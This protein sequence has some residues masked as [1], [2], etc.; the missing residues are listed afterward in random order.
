MK[1]AIITVGSRGDVEPF[2]ALAARLLVSGHTVHF[3]VQSDLKD[4]VPAACQVHTLPFT[5]MDF[6]KFVGK[7]SHG[8]DHPNP[9]VGFVGTVTDIIAGLVLPCADQLASIDA[10]IIV[11]SALARQLAFAV[12]RQKGIPAALVHLQPL[13]PTG[14]FSHYSSW[15]ECV[16]LI[17]E[18]KQAPDGSGPAPSSSNLESYIELEK[19]QFDFL[20]DRLQ[21]TYDQLGIPAQSFED[22]RAALTGNNDAIL[23][24]NAFAE[25]LVPQ[26]KDVGPNVLSVGPLADVYL[27][28]GF[29]PPEELVEFLSRCETR[30]ICVGFGSMPF[31]KA[32]IVIDVIRK[33]DSPAVFVGDALMSKEDQDEWYKANI[34]TISSVQYAW[35]LPR[36]SMML[37]HGGAGVVMATMR[38]GIPAVISPLMGDQ[39]FW[40]RLLEALSL[41]ARAGALT[42]VTPEDLTDAINKVRSFSGNCQA[43]SESLGSKPAGAEV[44][45]N[46]LETRVQ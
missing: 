1:V 38:A 20:A 15:D 41:G 23:I 21:G 18:I 5:K 46:L 14:L 28:T 40:G 32:Q 43:I 16:G 27:P 11:T 12:A 10:D 3:L 9:R 26:V 37:S 35:L 29:H 25:E 19:F 2:S 17:K 39:F 8:A 13:V 44:M 7:P 24:I 30:P 34:F 36:C 6:Y 4:L 42:S 22:L 45:V 33:L 31:D